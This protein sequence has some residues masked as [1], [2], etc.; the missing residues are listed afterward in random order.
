MV[1][2]VIVNVLWNW[3]LVA[4]EKKAA[5]A[6]DAKEKEFFKQLWESSAMNRY[7]EQS[8]AL[9]KRHQQ[10]MKEQR[11]RHAQESLADRVS[12]NLRPG[13]AWHRVEQQ[14]AEARAM[15]DRHEKERLELDATE[16]KK[17]PY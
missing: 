10:E 17:R 13:S 6:M 9:S 3:K 11:E 5:A 16:P 8:T 1:V 2:W 12:E 14:S 4:D 15:W 7:L